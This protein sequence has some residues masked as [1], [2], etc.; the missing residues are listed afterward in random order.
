MKNSGTKQVVLHGIMTDLL[1]KHYIILIDKFHLDTDLFKNMKFNIACFYLSF[2]PIA[3][4]P[5][6]ATGYWGR[7]LKAYTD[8]M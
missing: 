6:S 7:I 1:F 2:M 4:A 3:G 8:W 5:Q